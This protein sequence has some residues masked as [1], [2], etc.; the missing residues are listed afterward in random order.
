MQRIN[1]M[2]TELFGDLTQAQKLEIFDILK[3]ESKGN[4]VN[5][6]GKMVVWTKSP[7]IQK[8][9][10]SLVKESK[11]N[12]TRNFPNLF[13]SKGVKV[14]ADNLK[15]KN[16]EEMITPDEYSVKFVKENGTEKVLKF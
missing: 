14:T 6:R 4:V 11:G 1:A 16:V 2:E 8:K 9:M 15:D 5:Q 13:D 7:D 10:L 3:D 12:V